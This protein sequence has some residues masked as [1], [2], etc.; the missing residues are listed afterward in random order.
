MIVRARL[1]WM[2]WYPHS[3]RVNKPRV[4]G[5][6]RLYDRVA[7]G[8][9]RMDCAVCNGRLHHACDQQKLRGCHVELELTSAR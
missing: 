1:R 8:L 5:E 2:L 7:T 6:H 3:T 4:A 9:D